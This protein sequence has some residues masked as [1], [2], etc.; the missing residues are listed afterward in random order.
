MESLS[1]ELK[2]YILF[3]TAL[4]FV[5]PVLATARAIIKTIGR[6]L[7]TDTQTLTWVSVAVVVVVSLAVVGRQAG[8]LYGVQTYAH[9]VFFEDFAFS[10]ACFGILFATNLLFKHKATFYWEV[11]LLALGLGQALL[12]WHAG[13]PDWMGIPLQPINAWFVW[14]ASRMFATQAAKSRNPLL[15]WRFHTLSWAWA[16]MTFHAVLR[17]IHLGLYEPSQVWIGSRLTM[18]VGSLL[19]YLGFRMPTWY[20]TLGVRTLVLWSSR[21]YYAD[22][23]GLL[24][25]LHGQ[26]FQTSSAQREGLARAARRVAHALHAPAGV[27]QVTYSTAMVAPVTFACYGGDEGSAEG[28]PMA[29]EID[30]DHTV[31][32][33]SAVYQCVVALL[34][35]G[36]MPPDS[37]LPAQIVRATA[38][39]LDGRP[40]S[41]VAATTSDELARVTMSTVL[42]EPQCPPTV[43]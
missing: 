15:R 3:V 35:P 4:A 39:V 8:M 33:F 26:V 23:L 27:N 18:I 29:H 36:R 14:R 28:C 11:S 43:P 1:P 32:H 34:S 22:L 16:T 31:D 38:L 40:F 30:G 9:F 42:G 20:R 6:E 24:G 2:G 7:D 10:F 41:C 17:A 21:R 12:L 25:L 37:P 13:S 5:L 19:V